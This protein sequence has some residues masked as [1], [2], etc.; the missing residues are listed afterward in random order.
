MFKNNMK[1]LAK[2]SI[3]NQ[4]LNE[5]IVTAIFNNIK[6]DQKDAIYWEKMLKILDLL[7]SLIKIYD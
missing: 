5:N 2:I 6:K 1:I 7:G 3:K 4:F